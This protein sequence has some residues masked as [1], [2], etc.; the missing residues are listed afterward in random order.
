MQKPKDFIILFTSSQGSSVMQEI[1]NSHPKIQFL[2]FEPFDPYRFL[3]KGKQYKI[4]KEFCY[5]NKLLNTLNLAYSN[6]EDDFSRLEKF[7]TKHTDHE[8]FKEKGTARAFKFRFTDWITA[9]KR[10]R[11]KG[12]LTQY[13][14]AK[15]TNRTLRARILDLLVEKDVCIFQL[16]RK[17]ILLQAISRY[18]SVDLQFAVKNGNIDKD[19][20]GKIQVDIPELK[21]I[22]KRI[23]QADK[24]EEL[25]AKYL[26][27]KKGRDPIWIYYED[28]LYHK[29]DFLKDFLKE[30]GSDTSIEA[31]NQETD[32][33]KVHSDRI[34]DI[35]E[36]CQE[37]LKAF[38]KEALLHKK[39]R[40]EYQ[41]DS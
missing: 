34:E 4:Y 35:V 30:I 21:D 23:R 19:S 38:P 3:K 1:L 17:D 31:L 24:E 7:Y 9:Q 40:E 13:L 37:V 12:L 39:I 33:I 2:G 20:L 15:I 11:K 6:K 22:I 27:E 8:L 26:K 28:F 14:F 5:G 36:N 29:E 18:R 10:L 41:I 32:Y 16:R 25:S